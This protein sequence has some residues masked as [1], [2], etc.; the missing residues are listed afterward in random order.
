MLKIKSFEFNPIQENTYI[1]YNRFNE[2]III[3]PGCYFD[4]EKDELTAF[5]SGNQ[6][7]PKILLNTHCHL[8]HIFGNKF[9]AEKYKLTPCIHKN[10]LPVFQFA[11]A[12]GLMYNLPFDNYS[13]EFI[14]L[15]EGEEIKLGE[16]ILKILFTPGHSPG[17][18]S[19]YHPEG[20]FVISGDALFNGSIGRTDLPLGNQELL[21]KR[22]KSELLT[23]PGDTVVYC[24]HGLKTTIEAEKKFNPFLQ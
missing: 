19:F 8:D 3:D 23:L 10:E 9:V 24:G 4:N 2:C 21:I 13:G 6:L 5:I 22:I 17:S 16:D 11:P 20:G 15:K 7:T 12:S 1:L 14:F 18:L